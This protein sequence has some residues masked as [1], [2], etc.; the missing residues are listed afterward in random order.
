MLESIEEQAEICVARACG[1]AALAIFTFMLGLSWDLA[2]ACKTGGVLVLAVSLIL[3]VKGL[4]AADRPVRKTELWMTLE[5]NLRPNAVVAQRVLGAIL[6]TCYLRFALH[7]ASVSVWLLGVS[8]ALGCLRVE[9]PDLLAFN[10]N[11]NR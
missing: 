9:A 4:R 6:R 10:A 5:P 3:I 7:A 1:F 11:F 2:L 8:L